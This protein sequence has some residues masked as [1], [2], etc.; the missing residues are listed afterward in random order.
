MS[1]GTAEIGAKLSTGICLVVA[2][3]KTKQER[4]EREKGRKAR[5]ERSL[6]EAT[7]KVQTYHELATHRLLRCVVR[8]E[9][10]GMTEEH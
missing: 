10:L 1:T 8:K 7:A 9:Y 3:P 6:A 2:W 5:Q 4:G